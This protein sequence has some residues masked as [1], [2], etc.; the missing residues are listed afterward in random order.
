MQKSQYKRTYF[1]WICGHAVDLETCTSDEQGMTVHENCYFLKLALATESMRLV[2]RKP[3]HR[4]RV[5]AS[6]MRS[7]KARPSIR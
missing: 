1:C 7:R 6:E 5:A 2:V 3:A 4:V